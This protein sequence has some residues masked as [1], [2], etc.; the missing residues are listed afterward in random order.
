MVSGQHL[1]EN[2]G[3]RGQGN[4]GTSSCCAWLGGRGRWK[5]RE[6]AQQRPQ[7]DTSAA[8]QEPSGGSLQGPGD[9]ADSTQKDEGMVMRVGHKSHSSPTEDEYRVRVSG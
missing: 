8:G 1:L 4:W 9:R 3:A 6:K 2:L 7:R 5:H